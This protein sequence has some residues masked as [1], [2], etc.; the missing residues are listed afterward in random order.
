MKLYA[1]I[2]LA[3]YF[4]ALLFAVTREKKN[5]NA[6]EYFFAGRT[7][8]SVALAITFIASW[9][10]AGSA[11]S[12]ADLAY[13]DGMGAFFYYGVPVLLSTFLLILTAK[14]V[15][16]VG[17]LTQGQMME[18]RYSRGVSKILSVMILIFMT[19]NAASQMV[20]MGDFFGSFLG[21]KYEWGV[22][23]GTAIVLIYSMFGGFRAVVLTDIIQFV[24]LTV[25][26][27]T[28]F[29]V[30]VTKAG[31]FGNIAAR[32]A[33]AGKP[34]YM[35][36][37]SGASK[38]FVYVIT[39]GTSWMIQA[40]VWQR[41]SAARNKKDARQ[42]TIISFFAYIP[43]YLVVVLT[44]M[45]GFVLF[46]KGLPA[47]GIVSAI[48]TNLMPTAL[49]A[50]VF[51]GITAAI[52]STMDS[53]INTAAMTLTMDLNPFR[54]RMSDQGQLRFSQLA[55]LIITLIAIFISMQIR[56]ILEI[57]M[58]A[59]SVITTGAFVPLM[60]GF[61]WKRGTN[62]GAM[63][64][65]IFGLVYSIY[66][67]LIFLGV[68][69]PAFWEY[70]SAVMIVIGVAVSLILYVVVSLCTKPEFEKAGEFIKLA[71]GR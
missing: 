21:L 47:G 3:I 14:M 6:K 25:S 16:N 44:G 58:I 2:G 61:F 12:T 71:R 66:N 9:W 28:V 37:F 62:A 29:I 20:G 59:S 18:S 64:S 53:L 48:T 19:F 70:G 11:L 45:A 42:M 60:A 17:Y 32:S 40:N 67:F 27:L 10:G 36:V 49:A 26:A 22:L 5:T 69:L 35:N 7:L 13:T 33:A 8:S 1:L 38:Y 51:V 56:S 55:T 15:R 4:V 57:T 68:P 31:G 50:L 23:I 24:L 41:I 43:L 46:P 52:M 65:M 54:G 34:G 63:S 30:A 39:F